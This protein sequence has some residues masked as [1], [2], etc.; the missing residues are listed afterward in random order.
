MSFYFPRNDRYMKLVLAKNLA[1]KIENL[2]KLRGEGKIQK[3]LNTKDNLVKMDGTRVCTDLVNPSRLMIF[4][5]GSSKVNGLKVFYDT[6]YL[7]FTIY[8]IINYITFVY[9]KL[10]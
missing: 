7:M 9:A 4:S 6:F 3:A 2:E 8:H 10:S 5:G 1:C